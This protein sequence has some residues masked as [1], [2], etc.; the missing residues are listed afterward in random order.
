MT[1]APSPHNGRTIAELKRAVAWLRPLRDRI[2]RTSGKSRFDKFL[3][4]WTLQ[5]QE[6]PRQ[7]PAQLA[8]GSQSES[9]SISMSDH[10]DVLD[11]FSR[12]AASRIEV[13]VV[14]TKHLTGVVYYVTT[15]TFRLHLP[16]VNRQ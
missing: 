2:K 3:F 6:V 7:N 10:F 8:L 13:V 4:R 1:T 15:S 11:A 12:I 9:E 16:G 14:T 5:T